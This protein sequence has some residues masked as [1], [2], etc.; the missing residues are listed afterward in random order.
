MEKGHVVTT[1]GLVIYCLLGFV[2]AVTFGIG[3][4]FSYQA[5]TV[6]GAPDA[7]ALSGGVT[8]MLIGKLIAVC[9]AGLGAVLCGI[10]ILKL[11]D[12][13]RLVWWGLLVGSIFFL[14][15]FPVGTI[16]GALVL[17]YLIQNRGEF[18]H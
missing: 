8:I 16:I 5:L 18:L 11:N 13:R 6:A 3:Q 15:I 2:G 10:G 12:R 4:L 9:S 17:L 14:P 1:L 7:A